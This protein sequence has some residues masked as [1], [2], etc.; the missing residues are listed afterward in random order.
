MRITRSKKE[1]TAVIQ[2]VELRKWLTCT[3][4]AEFWICYIRMFFARM[5]DINS[6]R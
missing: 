5:Y 6:S 3:V 4:I 1:K 2:E